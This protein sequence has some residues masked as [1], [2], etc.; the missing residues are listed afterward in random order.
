MGGE[1]R[2]VGNGA[3]P[4]LVAASVNDAAEQRSPTSAFPLVAGVCHGVVPRAGAVEPRRRRPPLLPCR[5][6][7]MPGAAVFKCYR[8]IAE[9]GGADDCHPAPGAAAR[10]RRQAGKRPRRGPGCRLGHRP[11]TRPAPRRVGDK[12]FYF[13]AFRFTVVTVSIRRWDWPPGPGAWQPGA[14]CYRLELA[15]PTDFGVLR[16]VRFW[17]SRGLAGRGGERRMATASERIGGKRG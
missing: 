3:I 12:L 14:G 16:E 8:I 17:R 11:G 13:N 6:R 15:E 7:V 2:N 9:P 5:A 1:F 10:A 4:G